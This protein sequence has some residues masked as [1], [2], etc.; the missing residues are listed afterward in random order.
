MLDVDRSGKLM[1]TFVFQELAAQVDLESRYSLYQYR[2]REKRE[3]DFVVERDDGAILG[4]EAKAGHNVSRKDFAPQE[5]FIN[6]IIKNRKPYIGI[7]L[8]SGDRTI[9]YSDNLIAVPIASLW[10]D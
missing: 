7:V 5:W 8:Y 10:A 3:I 2:D 6:K 4:V 9:K 1:E